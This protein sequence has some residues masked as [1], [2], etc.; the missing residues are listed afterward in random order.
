MVLGCFQ[1]VKVAASDTA[2]SGS[3][4]RSLKVWQEG[5]AAKIGRGAS[6]TLGDPCCASFRCCDCCHSSDFRFSLRMF[7]SF[8]LFTIKKSV[9][10]D[11]VNLIL[12]E[13]DAFS[14]GGWVG[15]RAGTDPEPT[16]CLLHLR[17]LLRR[18]V[19]GESPMLLMGNLQNHKQQTQTVLQRS[20]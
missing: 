14:V 5:R 1:E 3:L 8:N 10:L 15:G 9:Y 16:R 6:D 18:P 4:P 11:S 2:S 12:T 17:S 19:R 7:S 20:A 13:F